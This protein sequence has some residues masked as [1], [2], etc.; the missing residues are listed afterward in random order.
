MPFVLIVHNDIPMP[1]PKRSFSSKLDKMGDD[2]YFINKP[3]HLRST[4]PLKRIKI[5]ELNATNIN[6]I[7]MATEEK[8]ESV[9]VSKSLIIIY[10]VKFIN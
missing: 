10:V 2:I 6:D 4:K 9:N 3:P 7:Q 5:V 1:P 8:T